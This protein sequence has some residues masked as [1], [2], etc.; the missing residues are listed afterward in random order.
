M[1]VV[2]FFPWLKIKEKIFVGNIKLTPY[3]IE[4]DESGSNI[5][6]ACNKVFSSYCIS[7]RSVTELTVLS[8]K[9]KLLF[10]DITDEEINDL[11][12]VAEFIAFCAI[13]RREYFQFSGNYC[14]KDDFL[15]YIQI[16][17][18]T[19]NGA[20]FKTR[21]RDGISEKFNHLDNLKIIKPD[22]ANNRTINIDK[23]LLASLL[24]LQKNKNTKAYN[25]IF[26]SIYSF[27]RANTDNYYFN[28]SFEIVLLIGAI[29]RIL[30]YNGH[31]DYELSNEFFNLFKPS[32]DLDINESNKLKKIQTGKKLQT[33]R[34]EWIKDLYHLRG[35]FAHGKLY[36]QKGS[37]WS[38]QEHL[39]LASY[40]FPLLVKCRL[41][42]EG[43][44]KLI[45]KDEYDENG[46]YQIKYS[47]LFQINVFE[48]LLDADLFTRKKGEDGDDNWPWI[49]IISDEKLR[50]DVEAAA[51]SSGITK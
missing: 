26:E 6:K 44:Y 34:Q 17:D 25:E 8:Y 13:S 49:R 19:F 16:F 9:D 22:N 21:R 4:Q 37:I 3:N 29:Q 2:A 40:V 15:F 27:N 5:K 46:I 10:D 33:L 51:E 18:E 50:D 45:E 43:Y 42:K 32:S 28:E 1:P 7:S 36:S 35:D 12:V 20:Y 31:K 41:E 23:E 48:K 24:E 14:N 47:D 30:G 38:A 39:L 11:F